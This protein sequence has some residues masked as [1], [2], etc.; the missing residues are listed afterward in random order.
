MT[1]PVADTDNRL[2][3]ESQQAAAAAG[4][5]T[6]DGQ[7]KGNVTKSVRQK[8]TIAEFRAEFQLEWGSMEFAQNFPIWH[9][10]SRKKK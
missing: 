1:S 6:E 7:E 8:S 3:E 4:G 2:Q 9:G 10:K 5:K